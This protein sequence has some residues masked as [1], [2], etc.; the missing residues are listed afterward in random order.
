MKV[1][2]GEDFI[3]V[4]WT[5]KRAVFLVPKKRQKRPPLFAN[6]IL[7]SNLSCSWKCK[8]YQGHYFAWHFKEGKEIIIFSQRSQE[9]DLYAHLQTKWHS[10]L[11]APLERHEITT[12]SSKKKATVIRWKLTK[13]KN[14]MIGFPFCPLREPW[15]KRKNPSLCTLF[16]PFFMLSSP[17]NEI[18]PIPSRR[19]TN[20]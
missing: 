5:T 11:Y 15:V 10:L 2:S 7:L 20:C 1:A 19:K 6:S 8:S 12:S 9:T 14:Y 18:S 16:C 3:L 17:S 4:S 13:K